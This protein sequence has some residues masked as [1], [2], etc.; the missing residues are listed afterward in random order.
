M[1]ATDMNA[2]SSRSHTIFQVM[3]ERKPLDT[4]IGAD[5]K[6]IRSKINLVDLAGSEK[7]KPHQLNRFSEKRIQEMTSINQSLSNLGNC[8]R[9]LLERRRQHIPYRNSKLTRLLQDSLGGNT[10]TAF[11]V[12][13]SPSSDALEETQS[14][15]Q[16]ADRAKKVVVHA[17]VNETLDDAS[18]L[19]RYEHQIARLK[20]ML[21]KSALQQQAPSM[22]GTPADSKELEELRRENLVL[23]NQLKDV[24]KQL[25][26]SQEENRAIRKV[27]RTDNDELSA[28]RASLEAQRIALQ[29]RTYIL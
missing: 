22:G 7:W 19:R 29:K 25:H 3:I 10:K 21:K 13:M 6:I 8:V 15:V 27:I 2:H 4:G 26:V 14:T 18:I 23:M 1:V 24:R 28:A 11:V 20:A 5:T 16:F 9:A 12:T 17:M